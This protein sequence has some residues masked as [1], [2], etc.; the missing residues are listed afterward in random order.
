MLA[1]GGEVYVSTPN[2]LT[3]AP[4]GAEKSDNP[5]HVKEYKSHEFRELCQEVFRDVTIYGL[6]HARKLRLHELVI[7]HAGWDAIHKKLG[8]TKFFYDRFT[9]AISERDFVLRRGDTDRQ[10]EKAL[11]F[12]AVCGTP[13]S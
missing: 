12:V 13:R 9:P 3:L 7:R 10:L 6:F 1:D 8:F 4:E 2:L 11:D 5:W